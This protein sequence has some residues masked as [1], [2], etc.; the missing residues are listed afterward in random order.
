MREIGRICQKN[1][2]KA[3]SNEFRFP[4]PFKNKVEDEKIIY[5]NNKWL[6]IIESE[7]KAF[8][9]SNKTSSYLRIKRPSFSQI[10]LFNKKKD[11]LVQVRYRNGSED[12]VIE[13]PG[14][15]IENNENPKDAAKR[16]LKEE[17]NLDN[18]NLSKL[19]ECYM[20]PMRSNFKGYFFKGYPHVDIKPF[21]S[22]VEG[23]L[24]ESLFIWMNRFQIK[25]YYA[26]FPSSS[27]TALSLIDFPRY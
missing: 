20:D 1:L 4:L 27:I 6:E 14:G 21:T 7:V 2:L 15:A 11:I 3:L 22:F 12:Y 10:I 18:I 23:E 5:I 24:E 13:F 26:L 9:N 17:L 25:K 8:P 16:E 19:G